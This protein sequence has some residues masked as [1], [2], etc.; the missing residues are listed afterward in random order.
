MNILLTGIGGQGVVLA[1]KILA[2]CAMER[3]LRVRSAETIGMAQRGGSVTSHVRIG[4]DILSPLIPH[5]ETDILIG[6]EPA[7]SARTITYLKSD[8]KA[9]TADRMAAAISTYDVT[10]MLTYLKSLGNFQIMDT[11]SLEEHGLLKS[12]NIAL[13]ATASRLGILDF[14]LEELSA[15]IR[16]LVTPKY[17]DL[18]LKVLHSLYCASTQKACG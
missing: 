7:E 1:S 10:A 15:A 14:T 13:L 2:Y 16:S 9:L 12:L 5:G 3:N 17:Q 18:N 4:D 11:T 8:G 6:F